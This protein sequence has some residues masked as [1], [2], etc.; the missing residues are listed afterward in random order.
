[1]INNYLI[2]RL[3]NIKIVITLFE[4][5]YHRR[6]ILSYLRIIDFIVYALKRI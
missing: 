3:L 1:M 6:F 4:I 2:L 5:I